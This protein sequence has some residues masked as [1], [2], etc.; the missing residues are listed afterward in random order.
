MAKY[1]PIY[2]PNCGAK[3]SLQLGFIHLRIHFQYIFFQYMPS[4]PVSRGAKLGKIQGGC[5]FDKGGVTKNIEFLRDKNIN[6]L[7][8][9]H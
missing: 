5:R 9:L 4:H 6:F 7:E 8:F 2:M 1:M 3:L